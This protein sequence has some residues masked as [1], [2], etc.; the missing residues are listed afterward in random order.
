MATVQPYQRITTVQLYEI[1][2]MAMDIAI[3]DTYQ[4]QSVGLKHRFF[5]LTLQIHLFEVPVCIPASVASA[6]RTGSCRDR[7][8][9]NP[10]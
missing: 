1:Q 9:K 2:R 4:Y 6:L 7:A 5:E 3:S 10:H 8:I